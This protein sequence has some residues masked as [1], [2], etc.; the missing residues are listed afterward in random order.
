MELNWED[1]NEMSYNKLCEIPGVGKKAADRIIA[2]RPYRSNN[3]LFK[4]RGLGKKTLSNLG[5]EKTKKLR[6]SWYLMD[7]GIEYPNSALAKHKITGKI[8]FFWRIPRE[9]RNYLADPN[10]QVD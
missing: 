9:H 5:I 8:D 4:V 10:N 2:C 7:D 6:R 1:F 3:D